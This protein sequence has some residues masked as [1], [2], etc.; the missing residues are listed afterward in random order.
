[1]N[2]L[3]IMYMNLEIL[4]DSLN[5]LTDSTDRYKC[6]YDLSFSMKRRKLDIFHAIIPG[7]I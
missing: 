3:L 4:N 6:C 5:Y 1:M 7:V 2:L